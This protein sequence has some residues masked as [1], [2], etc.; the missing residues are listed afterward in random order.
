MIGPNFW[1]MLVALVA[2]IIPTLVLMI[3]VIPSYETTVAIVILEVVTLIMVGINIWSFAALVTSDPGIIPRSTS[4]INKNYN[5]YVKLHDVED[6]S[7]KFMDI[8]LKYCETCN[9]LRPPRS[10]HC[11]SCD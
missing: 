7:N 2:I 10:F 4:Q 8:K 1:I 5:Y 11:A 6:L 9:V 3:I